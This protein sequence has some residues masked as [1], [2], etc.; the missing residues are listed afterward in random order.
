MKSHKWP[1]SPTIHQAALTSDHQRH[2]LVDVC[3]VLLIIFMVVTPMLG[4]RCAGEP[5][6]TSEAWRRPRN[7]ET[8]HISV[9]ARFRLSRT[10]VV[11]G[12]TRCSRRSIRSTVGT[13][14]ARSPS[15]EQARQV[16][17]RPSTAEVVPQG[18][19]Q[20]TW[21]HASRRNRQGYQASRWAPAAINPTSTST[22]LVDVVLVLLI[23]FIFI[24]PFVHIGHLVLSLP[25]VLRAPP[26]FLGQRPD[27]L[28]LF[29]DTGSGSTR[30]HPA[31]RSLSGSTISFKKR[32]KTAIRRRWCSS[33]GANVTTTRRSRSRHGP[34]LAS[35]T[36][37][38]VV[39]EPG[40]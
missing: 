38:S 6:R 7:G 21:P 34:S 36:S 12:R 27:R 39:E 28:R 9:K 18:R 1:S 20:Q 4:K 30:R 26:S 37:S 8:A 14:T 32:K 10:N 40:Q 25:K 17:R 33:R 19:L 29:S 13:P 23:I 24:T 22:P 5:A 3:L 2:P 11:V 35:R 15:G 16:W 31:D